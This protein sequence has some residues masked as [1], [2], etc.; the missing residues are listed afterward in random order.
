MKEK[1]T[2]FFRSECGAY[3]C[4]S[5]G[6]GRYEAWLTDGSLHW[7][8]DDRVKTWEDAK[9]P[10]HPLP[11]G[12]GGYSARLTGQKPG[13]F[14]LNLLHCDVTKFIEPYKGNTIIEA[15]DIVFRRKVRVIH[16][17]KWLKEQVVS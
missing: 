4:R 10:M 13:S 16:L 12:V 5:F 2:V 1:P 15:R 14:T 8:D 6:N 11:Y 3:I 9:R 7:V 17:P